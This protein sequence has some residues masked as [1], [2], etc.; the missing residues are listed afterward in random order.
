MQEENIKDLVFD[1]FTHFYLS[2]NPYRI[3]YHQNLYFSQKIMLITVNPETL[4]L[5]QGS[6]II[7]R[8]Q[9]WEDYEDLLAIRGHKKSP[10][11]YFNTHNQEIR[12]MSPLPS[13]VNRIDTLRDLV[14]SLLRFQQKDWQSFDPITLKQ[15]KQAGVEP[16]TCFYIAN[17]QAILGKER[18]DLSVDPPPDLAIEIDLTSLTN[19]EAYK[20][21]A[22]PELWIYNSGVLKIYLFVDENY[23]ESTQSLLFGAWDVKSVFSK[24][25]E[26]AWNKGSSVALRQFEQ[27]ILNLSKD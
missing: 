9:T 23:Q 1:Y 6:E 4:S 14:K 7:L 13:Q 12:L 18:I 2:K 16:D 17:Y 26:L 21:I 27:E 19:L 3:S 20:P 8:N 10:K 22:I 5:S 15:L 24:Y 25:V 11:L